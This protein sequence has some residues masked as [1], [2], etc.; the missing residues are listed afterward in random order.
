MSEIGKICT[1][2]NFLEFL[3]VEERYDEDIVPIKH[4]TKLSMALNQ[5]VDQECKV[6]IGQGQF[7]HTYDI[8]TNYVL[9]IAEHNTK[10]PW[11]EYNAKIANLEFM[12]LCCNKCPT[13]KK[14]WNLKSSVKKE[15]ETEPNF[16][17]MEQL[18]DNGMGVAKMYAVWK[19]GMKT[20]YSIS[21]KYLLC[22]SDVK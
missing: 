22:N 1:D 12:A 20:T 3:G 17:S 19:V 18:S 14:W 16:E 15:M 8:G 11:R 10:R 4:A 9:Q 21:E 2:S 7:N 6:E 13:K 5:K